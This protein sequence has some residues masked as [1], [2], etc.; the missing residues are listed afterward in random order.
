MCYCRY[1]AKRCACV[2]TA[3]MSH[4]FSRI[5]DYRVLVNLEPGVFRNQ[6][7]RVYSIWYIHYKLE[8]LNKSVALRCLTDV[9]HS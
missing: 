6:R 3:E 5:R 1:S 4:S 2:D 7:V 9:P 8:T